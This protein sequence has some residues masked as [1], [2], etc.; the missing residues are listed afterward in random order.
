MNMPSVPEN[1]FKFLLLLGIVTI[2]FP[3]YFFL[4]SQR[5]MSLLLAKQ[6][7]AIDKISLQDEALE[8]KMS[9][10]TENIQFLINE[11]ELPPMRL[12]VDSGVLFS[13]RKILMPI[14]A[15]IMDSIKKMWN[16]Y[17]DSV[18]TFSLAAEA[19]H[20]LLT[21]IEKKFKYFRKDTLFTGMA[22]LA[23]MVIIFSAVLG[24]VRK[25]VN[26][27]L[28]LRNEVLIQEFEIGAKGLRINNCQSC[29]LR[30]TPLTKKGK[31]TDGTVNNY[32]CN[33]CYDDG[34]FLDIELTEEIVFER[35]V[36]GRKLNEKE[37]KKKMAL[38][39]RLKRWAPKE[40]L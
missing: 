19:N 33:D 20:L 21:R 38:I 28:K 8:F 36:S 4:E 26:T 7:E 17:R 2:S 15:E 11:Y 32:F 37:A 25:E 10:T 40:Y 18:N 3:L 5:E 14:Q 29:G 39:K 6:D 13:N 27:D 30:F 1:L 24:Q 31:D 12:T 23:G 9:R 16:E 34:K 35:I 22:I